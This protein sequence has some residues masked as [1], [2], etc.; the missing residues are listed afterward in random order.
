MLLAGILNHLFA[1]APILSAELAPLQGRTFRVQ[2][3]FAAATVVVTEAGLLADSQADAE[4]VLTLPARFFITRWRDRPAA[5]RLV[6]ISGDAEL[7]GKVG[8]VLAA[9]QW[10]ASE[11]LSLLLGDVL[12]ERVRRIAVSMVRTPQVMGGRMAQTLVEYCRDEQK[13]LPQAY[14][15]TQFCDQVD[16]LR[17]DVARLELRLRR[18]ERS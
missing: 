14:A 15:V 5:S 18:L 6:Q 13:I 17:D 2:L 7:A 16:Q 1:Q 8:N 9:L 12:A 11:D 3:P 10:D 4:A